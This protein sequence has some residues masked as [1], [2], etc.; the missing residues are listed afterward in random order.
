[1]QQVE[2]LSAVH[3]LLLAG[4]L[5]SVC[6]HDEEAVAQQVGPL[7]G[8]DSCTNLP[9]FLLAAVKQMV[10]RLLTTQRAVLLL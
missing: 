1:M 9:Q 3:L 4:L 10:R 2:L 5:G 6:L 7:L 8:H